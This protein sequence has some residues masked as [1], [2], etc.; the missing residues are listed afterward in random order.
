[1]SQESAEKFR[2][3]HQTGINWLKSFFKRHPNL[4]YFLWNIFCPVWVSRRGF[5]TLFRLLPDEARV[6][7]LGSGPRRIA[8]SWINADVVPFE[9]VDI[10]ADAAELPLKDNSVDAVVSESLLEHVA[11]PVR[12]AREMARVVRPGGILYVSVP[13]LTPY[14]AS[15]DDFTRWTGSGLK[16]LFSEFELIEEGA[17]AGPWSAF[18]IFLAYGLGVAF[19]FGAKK[20]APTFAFFFM[21]ILGPFKIFDFLFVRLP[22]AHAVAAQLYFIGRKKKSG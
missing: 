3:E 22:G 18:L 4:Y 13:F 11:E 17:D 14:H 20:F 7:N 6:L 21:L 12:A 9:H 2:E 8:P 1:M 16:K 5:K 10:L 19:S 15:P